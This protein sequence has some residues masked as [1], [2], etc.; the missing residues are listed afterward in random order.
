MAAALVTLAR[1]LIIMIVQTGAFFAAEKGLMWVVDKIR[2]HHAEVNGLNP[3]DA[4]NA[5]A[6]TIIDIA[7]LAGITMLSLR[8]KLPVKIAE[9]LGFTSKGYIKRSISKAGQAKLIAKNGASVAAKAT[10]AQTAEEIATIVA[11]N[12]GFTFSTVSK[13]ANL[14]VA[15]V[16]IPVGVGLLVINTIDFAAWPSSSY[17]TTFQKFFSFFGLEP[18][19][20]AQSSKVLSEDMWNKV[21]NTYKQLGAV[22]INN[23]F[24]NQSQT[25]SR[26]TLIALVDKTA[27]AIIAEKGKVT[28][29]EIIAATQGFLVMSGQVTD[30]KINSAFGTS[31]T[32]SSGVITSGATTSNVKVF[33][34]I[35]SQGVVGAGLTFTPRPDDMIESIAELRD[36]AQNNLA[37][38]LTALPGKVIYEVKVVS[39]ILTKDGFKQTGQ[40]QRIQTGT[41]QNGQPKYKTVTNKF[42]TLVLYILTDKGTRSKITTIVLGPVDSAKLQVAQNDLRTLETQLPSLV[43]TT[44]I[45]EINVIKTDTETVVEPKTEVKPVVE[46]TEVGQYWLQI[47]TPNGNF[48]TGPFTNTKAANVAL[49][50]IDKQYAS[51]EALGINI[52]IVTTE[53]NYKT[54]TSIYDKDATSVASVPVTVPVVNSVVVTGNKPGANAVTLY[55]W[56]QAQGQALPSV[57]QRSVI[58]EGLGLG[59]RSYYTGTAEQNTKLLSALKAQ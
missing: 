22:G 31:A 1:Q 59:S 11:K 32:S 37:P 13:V 52:K 45:N 12:K 44:D 41:Y 27:A 28:L 20:E 46:N 10:T 17:Q 39:S 50:N 56:Y 18:D 3:E 58:Y 26:E 5:T 23:P 38:F 57:S 19:K 16:G 9:R 49:S 15:T 14:V 8:T 48:K 30:A 36:A 40:T 7:L 54:W 35:V 42:A 6:N 55:E 4:D 33:T 47:T 29:K 53:P 25:F 43:T 2:E 34:G 51:I 21:Y 24:T